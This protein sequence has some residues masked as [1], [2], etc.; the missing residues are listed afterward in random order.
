MPPLGLLDQFK[1][2]FYLFLNTSASTDTAFHGMIS[3]KIIPEEGFSWI[4]APFTSTSCCYA[5]PSSAFSCSPL[6]IP[7]KLSSLLCNYTI[8]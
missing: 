7:S 5:S 4:N 3:I 6:Q 2:K 8:N 1:G